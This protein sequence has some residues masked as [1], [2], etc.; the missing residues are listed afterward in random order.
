MYTNN[1]EKKGSL[2]H[3][4]RIDIKVEQ[5]SHDADWIHKNWD[6]D[7]W[8]YRTQLRYHS[9]ENYIHTFKRE[10]NVSDDVCMHVWRF[11]LSFHSHHLKLDFALQRKAGNRV[12]TSLPTLAFCQ[13]TRQRE[14]EVL[15]HTRSR[16]RVYR[17]HGRN[18]PSIFI[19]NI[20][21]L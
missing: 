11:S 16:S 6:Y 17:T 20:A 7:P 1:F 15:S 10:A 9:P 14:S 13:S 5:T 4:V 12:L 19:A 21:L 18:K 3:R 8:N 2:R